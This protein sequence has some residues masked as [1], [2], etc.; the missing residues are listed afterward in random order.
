MTIKVNIERAGY[1]KLGEQVEALWRFL[2]T[3][4]VE[5]RQRQIEAALKIEQ[6]AFDI[7]LRLL[8]DMV[9]AD[10]YLVMAEDGPSYR[11]FLRFD[12]VVAGDGYPTTDKLYLA[13]LFGSEY[14]A[15][16]SCAPGFCVAHLD[17]YGS[18]DRYVPYRRIVE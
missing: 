3:E 18:V 16:C 4:S 1:Q 5:D 9:Y 13:A 14:E 2:G 8:G 10:K 15:M 7:R 17:K 11:A 6:I 12:R